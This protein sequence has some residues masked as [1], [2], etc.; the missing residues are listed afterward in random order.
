MKAPHLDIVRMVLD[1]QLLD[2]N[3]IECGRVEDVELEGGPDELKVTAVITGPGA[4]TDHFPRWLQPLARRV[5]GHRTV[6]VP[7]AEVLIIT[8]RIKLKSRAAALGL[9]DEDKRVA[10]WLRKLPGS[11]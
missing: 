6:R 10:R 2:S 1:R 5:F 7:W 8:S 4:V 9:A 3:Y 11:E